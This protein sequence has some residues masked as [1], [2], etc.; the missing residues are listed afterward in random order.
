MCVAAG[1]NSWSQF[2]FE[3][4][5]YVSVFQ[6]AGTCAAEASNHPLSGSSTGD[7]ADMCIEI[8]RSPLSWALSQ[9]PCVAHS[10]MSLPIAVGITGAVRVC[11]QLHFD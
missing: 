10:C 2:A 8:F 11:L 5:A 4:L 7:C 3:R 1:R 9:C 6:C